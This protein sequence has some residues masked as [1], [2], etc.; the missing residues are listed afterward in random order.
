M[1]WFD[2]NAD[3][4]DERVTRRRFERAAG[5]YR[6]AA[7]F[8]REIAT[9]MLERLQYIRLQ[10]AWVIDL[11]CATGH[12]SRALRERYG[13]ARVLGID[14]APAMCREAAAGAG[15]GWFRR[16]GRQVVCAAAASLPIAD[17]SVDLV[18]AN[19][20][21][22]WCPRPREVL[23]ECQRVLRP[24]GLLMF[25]TLGPDSLRE[26]RQAWAEV[27]DAV[28]V[29][30]FPDMHDLGDALVGERFADP[31]MDV[32]WLTLTY[33]TFN[34]LLTDIR[35]TGTANAA[36]DR[37]RGLLGKRRAQA[38]RLAH[39]RCRGPDGRLPVTMEV[40]YG[41]AWASGA[42]RQQRNAAGEVSIPLDGLLRKRR[43]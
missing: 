30:P 7:V 37:D 28:H 5:R 11:G 23:R 34:A 4:L 20:L 33:A 40:V 39:E 31:V 22:H 29:H 42:R 14:F 17:Q 19:Q 25:S 26:L 2:Q 13:K 32:E 3:W 36:R 35:G 43:G 8:Q 38:L 6:A 15:V 24:G 21:L 16:A 41:H 1:D 27:D 9:R 12:A 10:P 18:F